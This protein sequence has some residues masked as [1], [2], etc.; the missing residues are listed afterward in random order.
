MITTVLL[1]MI[2][3]GILYIILELSQEKRRSRILQSFTAGI[4]RS[5]SDHISRTD[6][7]NI[8]S[9]ADIMEVRANEF[10]IPYDKILQNISKEFEKDF[11]SQPYWKWIKDDRNLFYES[12]YANDGFNMMYWDLFDK[13]L[14]D[15]KKERD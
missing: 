4:I 12:R 1:L 8:S 10:P 14:S 2:V 3:V 7:Q 15:I 9:A 5:V 6:I 13:A 11:W